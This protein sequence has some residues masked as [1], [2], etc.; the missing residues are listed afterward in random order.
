MRLQLVYVLQQ[1]SPVLSI[2]SAEC[3]PA[4]MATAGSHFNCEKTHFVR[5]FDV[6]S[7]AGSAVTGSI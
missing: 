5:Y 4:A 6:S 1:A 3:S 7:E 2:N